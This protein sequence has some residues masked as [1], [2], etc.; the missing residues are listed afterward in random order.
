MSKGFVAGLILSASLAAAAAAEQPVDL[1]LVLAADGSPSIDEE[2]FRLQREGYAHAITH[3]RVLAAIRSGHRQGIALALI[4]WGAPDSQHTIVDWMVIRDETSARAFAD[5][6]LAQPRKARGYNSISGA[7]DHAARMIRDNA[8]QAAS[9]II[10]VSGDG[11]QIGG[12]PVQAARADAVASGIVINALVVKSPGGG[13]RGPGGMPLDEHYERDV[14][15]GQ[16]SFVM[17]AD[18][19]D[20]FAQALVQKMIREIAEVAGASSAR[21]SFEE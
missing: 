13:V 1:E 21:A 4:E 9:R 20:S 18:G 16:G 2:E 19:R 17:V 11:P 14:I 7:I 12:R 3:P 6:L 8:F 15:G 10:D 5:K